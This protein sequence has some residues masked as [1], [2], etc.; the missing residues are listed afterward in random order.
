MPCLHREWLTVS[1]VNSILVRGL[2]D[3]TVI[4]RPSV[5]TM[6]ALECTRLTRLGCGFLFLPFAA[7][8]EGLA[9]AKVRD[10]GRNTVLIIFWM[11]GW[12][13]FGVFPGF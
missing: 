8:L 1:S 12:Y 4:V 2:G 5:S 10:V 6:V 9:V 11:V 7:N 3:L 13:F